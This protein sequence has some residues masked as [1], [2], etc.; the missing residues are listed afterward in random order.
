MRMFFYG[1]LKRGYYNNPRLRLDD[2]NVATFIGRAS[3][4]DH[5]IV[6]SGI[7]PYAVRSEGN[8]LEGEVFD[9]HD[10][11]IVNSIERMERGAG[12]EGIEVKVYALDTEST[13]TAMFYLS[14]G[15]EAGSNEKILNVYDHVDARV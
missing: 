3:L 12:Y 8:T 4:P 9:V 13:Y 14:R 10:E 11:N 15:G 1:T 2:P 6:M 5:G 7:L